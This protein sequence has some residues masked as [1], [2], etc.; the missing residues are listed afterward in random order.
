MMNWILFLAVLIQVESAGDPN[1]IGDLHLKNHAYGILQIRQPYLDD[2]NRITN[3]SFTMEQVAKS[4]ALSRWVTEQYIFHYGKRYTR[5]TG[6]PLT[7]E[8][9][10]RLHNGG[11]N[12]WRKS[13]TDKYWIK[14]QSTQKQF[15]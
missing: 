13:S 7:M 9:A 8:I 5:I 1:V 15:K 2:V 3:N 14:F 11:P 4:P 12:G 6:K 10:A